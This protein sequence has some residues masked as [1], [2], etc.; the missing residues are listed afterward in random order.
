MHSGRQTLCDTDVDGHRP[1]HQGEHRPSPAT[2]AAQAVM[3]M[4]ADKALAEALL[5]LVAAPREVDVPATVAPQETQRAL[6][7]VLVVLALA[8]DA[9]QH[10]NDWG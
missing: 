2:S 7:C 9:L 3:Q 5:Q 8:S 6:G 10:G 1:P 4:A